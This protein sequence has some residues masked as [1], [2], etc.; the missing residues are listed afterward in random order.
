[1]LIKAL[2]ND[3]PPKVELDIPLAFFIGHI[4]RRAFLT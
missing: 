1:M 3:T 4:T 2:R